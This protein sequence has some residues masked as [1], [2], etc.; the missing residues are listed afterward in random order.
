MI[1]NR[2]SPQVQAKLRHEL[3][4]SAVA[5]AV[6]ET[7]DQSRDN[8]E[9]STDAVGLEARATDRLPSGLPNR[10]R[11]KIFSPRPGH[12]LI[13]FYKRSLVPYSR[14][15]YSY[16]GVDLKD[17]ELNPGDIAEWLAFVNSGFHPEKRPAHL[18][19]AFPFEIPE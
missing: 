18:R 9:I 5:R 17:G 8:F 14:D 16:G 4:Q 11:I 7:I 13:F 19:R 12:T 1:L 3:A 6:C 10:G 15:R 2:A